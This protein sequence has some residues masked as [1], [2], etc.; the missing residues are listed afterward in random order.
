MAGITLAIAQ[1]SLDAAIAA[2]TKALASGQAYSVTA[3]GTGRNMQRTP[4]EKALEAVQYW[5]QQVK[6][7][8]ARAT[9]RG[10]AYT[11]VSN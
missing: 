8:S 7:L 11:V 2:H 10:R 6:L 1:A 3:G 4:A 5:D 9:G